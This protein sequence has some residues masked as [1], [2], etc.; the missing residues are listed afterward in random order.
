M[1][2][3]TTTT[4]TTHRTRLSDGTAVPYALA[5]EPGGA[6][7]VL[8]HGLTDAWRSFRPLMEHLPPDLRVLASTHR[9]HAGADQPASGYGV[10]DLAEDSLAVMGEA[11][12]ERAVIVGHSLGAAI[13]LRLA[14][15]HPER[16]AGLV[17]IGAFATPTENPAVLEVAE[18]VDE[19]VDPVDRD[20][21][22][23]FQRSTLAHPV[24]EAFMDAVIA[25]SASV[26]AH[27]WRAAVRGF[28]ACDHLAGLGSIEVPTRLM[29]GDGDAFVPAEDQHTLVRHI[30]TAEL[31]VVVGG[32]HDPHWE[33]PARVAGE[34]AEFVRATAPVAMPP[35]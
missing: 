9:G 13:A 6:P 12:F 34:L 35:H 21:V 5:G 31:Q 3:T 1:T 18:V 2:T 23:E 11:G 33:H 10:A 20:F 25:D 14:V 30:A 16:V 22:V 29:W 8:L 27:V 17:L 24:P 26:P 7:V 28:L 19:L 15:A 32:G 4:I